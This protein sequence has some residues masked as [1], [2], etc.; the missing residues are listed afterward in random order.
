MFE[1]RLRG[2]CLGAAGWLLVALAWL[3]AGELQPANQAS[4]QQREQ[5]ELGASQPASSAPAAAQQKLPKI[6][7]YISKNEIRKLLGKFI[8]ETPPEGSISSCL[9]RRRRR[10]RLA[11]S[12]SVGVAAAAAGPRSVPRKSAGRFGAGSA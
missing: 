2:C 12:V 3:A 4:Q 7:I 1:W 10:R 11:A 6:N 5:G 9:A 8:A